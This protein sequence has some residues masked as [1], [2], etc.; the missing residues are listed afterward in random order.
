MKRRIGKKG[1]SVGDIWPLALV[2]I[3][4]AIGLAFGAQVQDDI[5]SE[6][7][8]VAGCNSTNTSG[9]GYA[10]NISDTGLEATETFGDKLD[11]IALVIVA[12][13]VIG[14]L[15]REFMPSRM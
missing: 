10:K 13:I 12:A 1:A 6:W 3:V 15:V 14:L 8:D 5:R 4:T 9:C 7:Y 2:L 11:T